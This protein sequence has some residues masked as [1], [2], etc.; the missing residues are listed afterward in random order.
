M[1][2]APGTNGHPLR[3][4]IKPETPEFL[5]KKR[6]HVVV[7]VEGGG[8]QNLSKMS[9]D[10][11]LEL[12]KMEVHQNHTVGIHDKEMAIVD[13]ETGEVV[14]RYESYRPE[15]Q[16][17]DEPITPHNAEIR[18]RWISGMFQWLLPA[19]MFAVEDDAENQAKIKAK[20]TEMNVEFAVSP[21]GTMVIFYRNGEPMAAWKAYR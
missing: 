2:D 11:P 8:F 19:E 4:S 9:L 17:P 7:E 5:K 6:Y 20:L 21:G 16:G 14:A 1:N 18:D 13:A 10:E 12:L 15:P 3:L